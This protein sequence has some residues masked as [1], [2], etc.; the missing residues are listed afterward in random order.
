MRL[1]KYWERSGLLKIVS[2]P[3]CLQ[4]IEILECHEEQ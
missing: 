1:Q 3:T 4:K 2:H